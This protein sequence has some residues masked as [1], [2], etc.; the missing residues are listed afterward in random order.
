VSALASGVDLDG[1]VVDDLA[2]SFGGSLI[3]PDDAMYDAHRRDLE[4]LD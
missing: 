4:R 2:T 3:R 1:R